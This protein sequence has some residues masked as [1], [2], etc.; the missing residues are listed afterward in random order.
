MTN[1]P[2]KPTRIRQLEEGWRFT[3]ENRN[4]WAVIERRHEFYFLYI[5]NVDGVG[6]NEY[7]DEYRLE[8][9]EEATN[10][11]RWFAPLNKWRKDAYFPDHVKVPYYTEETS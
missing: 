5:Q 1:S 6:S 4:E 7:P 8:S 3:S 2:D 10:Y 11:M 9:I